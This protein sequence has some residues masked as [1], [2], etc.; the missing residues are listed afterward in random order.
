MVHLRKAGAQRPKRPCAVSGTRTC[1]ASPA[2]ARTFI[3]SFTWTLGQSVRAG[4]TRVDRFRLRD[5]CESEG[6]LS[7]CV[8][9]LHW[10]DNVPD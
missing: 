7:M 8:T 4:T 3:S 10:D 5:T 1:A 6:E 9:Q 2:C